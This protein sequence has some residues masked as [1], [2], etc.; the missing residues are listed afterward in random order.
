MGLGDKEREIREIYVYD[1]RIKD[2]VAKTINLPTLS[3]YESF[4]KL[5]IKVI[6][7]MGKN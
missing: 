6:N 3:T 7:S 1:Q 4:K 5:I 2:P